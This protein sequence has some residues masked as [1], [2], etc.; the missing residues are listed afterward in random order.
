MD[1]LALLPL[2]W[3]ATINM[4]HYS[5]Y[6]SSEKYATLPSI[7]LHDCN[8]TGLQAGF[9]Q[10]GAFFNV[11]LYDHM[12][13]HHR[14]DIP[15]ELS[16]TLQSLCLKVIP[17]Y[18]CIQHCSHTTKQMVLLPNFSESDISD[19][20]QGLFPRIS[21]L[22]GHLEFPWHSSLPASMKEH[23]DNPPIL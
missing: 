6:Q 22:Q 3:N 21:C 14:Q 8:A 19:I 10:T 23:P 9:C 7:C 13:L 1:G 17:L 4:V 15:I 20:H 16:F 12:L 5:I 2:S 18:Q 11:L